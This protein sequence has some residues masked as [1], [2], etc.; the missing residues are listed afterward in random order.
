M[1]VYAAAS[2]SLLKYP[3]TAARGYAAYT[4]SREITGF[5]GPVSSPGEF[6]NS[7]LNANSKCRFEVG[8]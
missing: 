3:S 8:A 4:T 2:N 5:V 1:Y 7:L 6:F